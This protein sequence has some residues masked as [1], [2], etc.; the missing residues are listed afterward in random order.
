[1]E[2][3]HITPRTSLSGVNDIAICHR[4]LAG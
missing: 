1:M 2:Q 4:R 3:G